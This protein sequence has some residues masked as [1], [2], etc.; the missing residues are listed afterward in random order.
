MRW[1][2]SWAVREDLANERAGIEYF[3]E[4]RYKIRLEVCADCHN[5]ALQKQLLILPPIEMDYRTSNRG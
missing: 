4:Q 5:I 1:L 2:N 3:H